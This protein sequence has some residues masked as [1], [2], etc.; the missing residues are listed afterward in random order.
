M[1]EEGNASFAEREDIISTQ[2]ISA[3]PMAKKRQGSRSKKPVASFGKQLG[4]FIFPS[5][6]SAGRRFFHARQLSSPVS[7]ARLLRYH[8]VV[9]EVV[10][11]RI[12][13]NARISCL[14]P[15]WCG[16]Q[17]TTDACGRRC[18][19]K[20][21]ADSGA[22]KVGGRRRH[23]GNVLSDEWMLIGDL[24]SSRGILTGFSS[25]HIS[26]RPA[27]SGP[28]TQTGT[29]SMNLMNDATMRSNGVD[30]D[31]LVQ[32]IE[33][34][35]VTRLRFNAHADWNAQSSYASLVANLCFIFSNIF[36]PGHFARCCKINFS[37]RKV[38]IL[39]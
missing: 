3:I 31:T 24:A 6:A 13:R 32:S 29:G 19:H 25:V 7:S 39:H 21:P 20:G 26:S 9:D 14:M 1:K 22:R 8:P 36:T 12:E 34:S 23:E 10:N 33:R 37:T 4:P 15:R 28:G 2:K 27:S 16:E 5:C 18:D 38:C 11:D 30:S 17:I 35:L